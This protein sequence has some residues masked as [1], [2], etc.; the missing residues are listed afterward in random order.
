MKTGEL[1]IGT[2]RL[3]LRPHRLE[4]VDDILEFATDPEWG[5][6][7]SSAPMP[8]RREHAVEFVARRILASWDERP[9]WAIVLEGKVVGGVGLR[10]DVEHSMGELGYSI[11]KRHWGR[12]LVVEAARAILEWGF[13]TC[14]LA[15]VYA[16]ADAR[17]AP[18]LRV[19]E[20]LGM[21][22]EGM[23]RSHLM[24]RDERIDAVYYGLLREE[25]E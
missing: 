3:L 4:D 22:R 17:N 24:L 25:W 11:A 2:E 13:R 18:S 19:M 5:R 16:I 14:G 20:K 7:L 23:L 6:Y 21:S 10:I 9:V 15:K 8:Y 12:G 1:E